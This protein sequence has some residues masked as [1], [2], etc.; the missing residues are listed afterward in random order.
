MNFFKEHLQKIL[1]IIAI[2]AFLLV[3]PNLITTIDTVDLDA[4]AIFFVLY[5]LMVIVASILIFMI[6]RKNV[7]DKDLINGSL[8]LL[9]LCEMP[10]TIYFIL[11][12]YDMGLSV[13]SNY[14]MD[15]ILYLIISIYVIVV[16]TRNKDLNALIIPL[17][18]LM[19]LELPSIF[20]NDK[21]STAKFLMYLALM[22]VI[23]LKDDNT[24][25]YYDVN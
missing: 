17:G 9:M 23:T 5:Y 22:L 19:V 7:K 1:Y 14:L 10:M 11:L 3:L 21:V 15:F 25:D 13:S 18:V 2:G 6:A 24:F 20:S 8:I 16:I 4:K 12:Q